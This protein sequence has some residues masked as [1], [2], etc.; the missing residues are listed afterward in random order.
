[1]A[2]LDFAG[3]QTSKKAPHLTHPHLCLEAIKYGIQNGGLAGLRKV[4]SL[5]FKVQ[6]FLIQILSD[7]KS[8]LVDQRFLSN[9]S[10]HTD[11][12]DV[13]DLHDEYFRVQ[14]I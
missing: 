8:I 4:L 11:P 5:G 6:F 2:Q 13:Y 3:L 1:M 14:V 9:G 7:P 10:C 12:Y